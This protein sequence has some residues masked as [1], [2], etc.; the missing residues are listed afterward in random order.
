MLPR[1]TNHGQQ[2]W[3]NDCS[4]GWQIKSTSEQI[5]YRL[6]LLYMNPFG[7]RQLLPDQ[8]HFVSTPTAIF[9]GGTVTFF[10]SRLG[11]DC[12]GITL[13]N[14]FCTKTK[15][16]IPIRVMRQSWC[17]SVVRDTH[18]GRPPQLILIPRRLMQKSDRRQLNCLPVA[19]LSLKK[20]W[21]QTILNFP[22]RQKKHFMCV[23]K[24]SEDGFANKE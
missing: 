2:S 3:T 19:A 22:P 9:M 7:I 12:V 18:T 10:W 16:L 8:S 15:Y 14:F 23:G 13:Y 17:V 24:Y 1:Q 11:P 5:V 4:C 20:T 6:W 21:C